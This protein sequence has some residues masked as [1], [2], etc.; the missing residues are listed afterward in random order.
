MPGGVKRKQ[1]LPGVRIKYLNGQLGTVAES[2]DGLLLFV[3][4]GAVAAGQTFE[5]GNPYRIQRPEGLESLGVTE[6]NNPRLTEQVR[7]FYN[8]ASEGTPLYVAGFAS[9]ETMTTLCDKDSGKLKGLLMELGGDIR[10]VVIAS[11]SDA[12]VETTEGLDPDVF[13][14]LPKAQALGEALAEA[15]YMPIFIALEGRSYSGAASLKD[16]SK[17]KYNRCCV[18][19][20]DTEPA[21]KGAA[22][23]TFAGAVAS[24]AVQRNIGRVADGTLYPEMMYLGEDSVDK[25]MD[26]VSAIYDKGYITPRTY[27]GRSGY[28]F[29]DDLMACDP[30][31]DYAHLTARRTVDK[32]ARIAYD[33]L[34]EIL[35]GEFEINEDGTMN[36]AEVKGIQAAVETA[37]DTAMTANGELSSVDGTGCSCWIDPSQNLV[38]TSRLEATIKVRPFGYA[39]YITASLGFLVNS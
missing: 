12:E 36:E 22:M 39:R 14:A 26:D 32:A 34:L 35:L 20:G 29:S 15:Y 13:T 8:E 3:M 27:V 10:G 16:L 6:E 37:I 5:L 9:S 33:T 25:V 18:V 28:Y 38:S 11:A 23:G 7:L 24:S 31:D 19:I 2:M 17:Q 1:M 4:I 21:S 30:T